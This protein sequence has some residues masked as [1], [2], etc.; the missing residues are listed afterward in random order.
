MSKSRLPRIA[1]TLVELLVVIA[2]IG[3]LVGLLLP[4][5]Q[6]AREAA[7][8]TQCIN[9][10]KQAGL[11][12]QNYYSVFQSFPHGQYNFLASYQPA[13]SEHGFDW[14]RR[15]WFQAILPYVEQGG[16]HTQIGHEH[17]AASAGRTTDVDNNWV[18]IA[19]FIWPSDPHAGKNTTFTSRSNA[20]AGIYGAAASQG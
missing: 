7:R 3:V 16:L 9:N 18:P 4:A 17:S 14:E 6:S 12:A 5:V 8:R 13:A 2:I 19:G 15:C 20:W 1:F 11:A 10:L